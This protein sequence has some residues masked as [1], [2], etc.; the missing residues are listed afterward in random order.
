[1]IH[2]LLV[3]TDILVVA[4][5][6]E[7]RASEAKPSEDRD[8]LSIGTGAI[9]V[10]SYE[11]SEPTIVIPDF[12]LR[13]RISGFQIFSLCPALFVDVWRDDRAGE[14]LD[15]GFGPVAAVR[16]DRAALIEDPQVEALGERDGAIE[17]GGGRAS[18]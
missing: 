18:P 13:A 10:P 2:K 6:V 9:M 11:A 12:V 16:L 5:L 7:L 4:F 17:L 3:G 8:L 14:S 1:M 15:V